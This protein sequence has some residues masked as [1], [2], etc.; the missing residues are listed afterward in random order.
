MICR[1]GGDHAVPQWGR[2]CHVGQRAAE[3]ILVV[4]IFASTLSCGRDAE[5][6]SIESSNCSGEIVEV[7]SGKIKL[8]TEDGSEKREV[9]G[10]ELTTPLCIIRRERGKFLIR[11]HDGRDGWWIRQRY[12]L[13]ADLL[14]DVKVDCVK[15]PKGNLVAT[16]GVRIGGSRG[17][18]EDPCK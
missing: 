17:S 9:M 15:P 13:E 16:T 2:R 12:V 6:N 1:M 3:G 18:G 4:V 7:V 14:P 11:M 5:A 10:T 8:K